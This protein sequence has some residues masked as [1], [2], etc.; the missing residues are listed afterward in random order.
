MNSK[1][2][3]GIIKA[4]LSEKRF[5]HS[6]N[7]AKEAV[8]IAGL[9]GADASKARTAGLLHDIAKDTPGPLQLQII[10][11]Y[12]IILDDVE[13]HSP[14]L[15]HAIAGA[16]VLQHEY[17]IDDGDIINAVRYHTTARA[18]MSLL[19]KVVYLA[20]FI[21][22]DR[23]FEGVQQLRAAIYTSLDTGFKAALNFSINE[24]V[25]K[26]AAI[27]LDTIRARNGLLCV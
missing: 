11:K 4:K 1:Y 6:C 17:G 26:G 21:S 27:H 20:D 9:Y 25:G 10:E 8:K 24:L 19:E 3:M 12:S 22:A 2:Y 14:K 23:N 7:V 5:I 13:S 18:G 15:W 16:L